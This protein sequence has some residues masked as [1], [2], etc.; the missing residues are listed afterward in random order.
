VW[1]YYM[2]G[3]QYSKLPGFTV[4][5]SENLTEWT[6]AQ[7]DTVPNLTP[8]PGVFGSKGFWA[9]Q[10]L[11][12]DS[13]TYMFYTA[14]EQIAI[15]KAPAI[16]GKYTWD[17]TAIDDS[18][19][20]ID[21]FLFT[22]TDG[23]HYLYH[24]RFDNG[25]WLWVGEFDFN[26]GHFIEGTLTPIFRNDQEWEHT[27]AYESA[28]IMEGPTVIKLGDI[29]YLF[30]SAN[31]FMSPDYAVG[32]ATATSPRGPWTKNPANPIIN[33]LI[34]G[35]KGSGHGDV[36]T[37]TDGTLRYVYHV[38][39]SDSIPNPRRTRIITLAVDSTVTPPVVTVVP[40]TVSYPHFLS[41]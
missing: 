9:P 40:S 13:C 41:K 6:P 25:N 8:G 3:T 23:R 22:D 29:Y 16:N 10:F 2:A 24:V 39:N 14:N 38:H 32:Y 27:L 12:T 31:H 34:V 19:K 36:F 11:V 4:L 28:P 17:G 33:R 15:A 7:T 18:E 20:N 1:N 35:E 37:A 5:T 26:T 21:P 30:Y